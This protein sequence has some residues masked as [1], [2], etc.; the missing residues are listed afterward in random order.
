[1]NQILLFLFLFW[2]RPYFKATYGYCQ[3]NCWQLEKH[4]LLYQQGSAMLIEIL[5]QYSPTLM[6]RH[7]S[8]R[9]LKA[10]IEKGGLVAFNCPDGMDRWVDAPHDL[11]G[12]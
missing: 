10:G 5:N 9:P 12:V 7:G 3:S 6:A 4:H 8:A 1:M 2:K 11:P